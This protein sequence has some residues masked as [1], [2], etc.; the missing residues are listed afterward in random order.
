M[1]LEDLLAALERDAAEEMAR[2]EAAAQA[3]AA[4]L[5]AATAA[6]AGR[7]RETALAARREALQRGTDR[8]LTAVRRAARRTE[9]EARAALIERVFAAARERLPAAIRSP[10]YQERLPVWLA[11]ALAGTGDA[12]AHIRC[13]PALLTTVRHL[14]VDRPG[15]TVEADRAVASGFVITQERLTVD[16]TLASRLT[17]RRADLAI[18]LVADL[19]R[20]P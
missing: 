18:A 20:A 14:V 13:A 8:E 10:A 12:P 1:A 15:L 19:E 3:A 17:L 9:L 7:Q 4:A 11:A 5:L 6:A 16:A 2:T